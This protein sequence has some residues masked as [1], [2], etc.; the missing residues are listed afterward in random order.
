MAA[1]DQIWDNYIAAH[2]MAAE[3]HSTAGE[4]KKDLGWY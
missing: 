4:L 1:A 2:F 3:S